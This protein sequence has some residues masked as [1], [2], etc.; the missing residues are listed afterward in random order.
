MKNREG[1]FHC[2]VNW[3]NSKTDV[4]IMNTRGTIEQNIQ[5]YYNYEVERDV[6]SMKDTIRWKY[7]KL[8]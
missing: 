4:N 7:S 5:G 8:I 2:N 1:S 3:N 6:I